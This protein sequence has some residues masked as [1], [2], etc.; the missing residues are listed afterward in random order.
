MIHTRREWIITR[1]EN[2]R[3]FHQLLYLLAQDQGQIVETTSLSL[4]LG[5]S[6]PTVAS[7]LS[8][9]DQTYVNILLQS[10]H[11]NLADEPRKSL[12]TYL[13]DLGIRS[14]ILKGFRP[15]EDRGDRGRI[16]ESF[17]LISLLPVLAPNMEPLFWRRKKG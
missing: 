8:T 6:A 1:E 13:H 17:V 3:A 12:R 11:T 5:R 7:Y 16:H 4:E 15:P 9:L 10:C 2:I 14:I